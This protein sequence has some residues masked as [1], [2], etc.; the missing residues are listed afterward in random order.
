MRAEKRKKK[1][2]LPAKGGKYSLR[3]ERKQALLKT[4]RRTAAS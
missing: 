1:Q 3:E 2:K 4:T